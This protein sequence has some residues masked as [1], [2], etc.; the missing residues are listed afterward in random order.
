MEQNAIRG[1]DFLH[2]D[3]DRRWKHFELLHSTEWHHKAWPK[4]KKPKRIPLVH[5]TMQAVFW[6]AEGCIFVKYFPQ[7]ETI[8]AT[9]YLHHC[10]VLLCTAWKVYTEGKNSSCHVTA[11]SRTSLTCGS[12]EFRT[13]ARNFF[14]IH[15]KYCT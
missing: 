7:E 6:D 3:S 2:N 11:F 12:G 4:K 8:D 15:H 10:R 1:D 14:C 9:H 5:K 13:T